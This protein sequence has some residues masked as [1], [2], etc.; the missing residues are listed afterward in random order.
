[1]LDIAQRPV[2]D[3]IEI[4]LTIDNECFAEVRR[5]RGRAISL[6]RDRKRWKGSK[7]I[8]DLQALFES[9]TPRERDV[10]ALVTTGLMKSRTP[11]DWAS[12]R[13]R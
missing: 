7:G 1:V 6:E 3:G 13:S 8:A 9:L 11:P 2:F 12:A 5:P 10:M 4:A